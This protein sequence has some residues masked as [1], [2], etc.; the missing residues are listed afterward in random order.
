MENLKN[1]VKYSLTNPVYINRRHSL[2]LL[3]QEPQ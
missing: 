1:K 3:I 2:N